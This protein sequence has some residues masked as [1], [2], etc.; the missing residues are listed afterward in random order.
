MAEMKFNRRTT[1][2][3]WMDHRTDED[4]SEELDQNPIENNLPQ[5]KQVW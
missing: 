5:Y 4:V 2:Y 1:G 3:G